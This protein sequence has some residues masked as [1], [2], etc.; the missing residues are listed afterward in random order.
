[1]VK[2]RKKLILTI[3]IISSTI[4]LLT[5]FSHIP[6]ITISNSFFS[7]D[8]VT[9][10]CNDFIDSETNDVIS[11]ENEITITDSNDIKALQEICFG[12]NIVDILSVLETPACFFDTVQIIF[13]SNGKQITVCPSSDGCNNLMIKT[14]NNYKNYHSLS[15]ME[16]KKLI[17][18]LKDNGVIWNC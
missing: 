10:K 18:I 3:S 2:A 17:K 14:E 16:M 15:E 5:V 7:A 6:Y 9:I 1:M 13:T 12:Q 4:I 11:R 8:K